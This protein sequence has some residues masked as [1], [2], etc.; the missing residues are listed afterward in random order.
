[1]H[2]EKKSKEAEIK[3]EQL[4]GREKKKRDRERQ[5]ERE[6]AEKNDG[7]SGGGEGGTERKQ[8]LPG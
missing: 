2:I 8:A 5:T 3:R 7:G 1:M 6:R 4:T